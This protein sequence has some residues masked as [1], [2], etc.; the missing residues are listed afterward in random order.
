MEILHEFSI[1][2]FEGLEQFR[3]VIVG[4]MLDLI[5]SSFSLRPSHKLIFIT[6]VMSTVLIDRGKFEFQPTA[7]LFEVHIDNHI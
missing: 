4:L 7:K 5:T 6:T 1:K 3:Q 2:D